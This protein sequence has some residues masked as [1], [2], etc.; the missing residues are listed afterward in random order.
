VQGYAVGSAERQLQLM[1][2]LS[3]WLERRRLGAEDLTEPRAARFCSERQR[4]GYRS[5]FSRRALSPLLGY[6]RSLGAAPPPVQPA[7]TPV[8]ALVED[9]RTYLAAERGLSP[10]TVSHYVRTARLFL[11]SPRVK[12]AGVCGLDAAVVRGFVLSQ[13]PGRSVVGAKAVVCDLRALLRFLHVRGFVADLAAAVPGVAGWRL[14]SL[15]RAIA[16]RD[17]KRLLASCDRR[18]GVGR[19]DYAILVL[20]SRLGLRRGEVARLT[21]DDIDWRQGE[22]VVHRKGGRDERLPLPADV[23]EAIAA[24]LRRGRPRTERR[25]LFV[26]A[27]APRTGLSPAGVSEVVVV[28]SERAGLAR[29]GAH[30]LRHTAASAMLRHGAPLSEVAEVLGHRDISTTAI[31]A[32]VDTASLRLVAAPWPGCGR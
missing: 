29:V 16:P 23:G 26:C 28:A 30:Q 21:L 2:H 32:K 20:L 10:G 22:L 31:Y 14:S 27:H 24:Y 9:Y 12:A 1:A 15:P 13:C 7:R 6:L 5:Y 17:L 11:S 18:R 8:D 4:A 19:R 3:R 25:E